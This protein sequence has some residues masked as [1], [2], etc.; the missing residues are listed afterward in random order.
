MSKEITLFLTAILATAPVVGS[1]A[2]A[3]QGAGTGAEDRPRTETAN[4]GPSVPGAPPEQGLIRR[5][6]MPGHMMPRMPG[7]PAADGSGYGRQPRA[8]GYFPGPAGPPHRPGIGY[9]RT[10]APGS[11]GSAPRVS[12]TEPPA[13]E[14]PADAPEVGCEGGPCPDAEASLGGADAAQREMIQVLRRIESRLARIESLL[15]QF[16]W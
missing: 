5:P 16:S 2:A 6:P 14:G 11:S 7:K 15:G 8:Y 9:G 10:A 4:S 13:P 12:S 3:G 1:E